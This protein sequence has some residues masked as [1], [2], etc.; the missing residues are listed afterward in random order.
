MGQEYL[1]NRISWRI[2]V[3]GEQDQ[4]EERRVWRTR[5]P[6]GQGSSWSSEASGEQDQQEDR[7][8]WRTRAPLGQEYLDNGSSSWRI[9]VSRKQEQLQ[10]RLSGEQAQL[11][12]MSIWSRRAAGLQLQEGTLMG[13]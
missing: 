7:R 12:D 1:D 10:E 5:G 2:E 4:Q 3:F 13:R 8:V 11:E 6:L 9:E